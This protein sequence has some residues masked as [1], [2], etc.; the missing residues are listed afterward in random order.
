MK[1]TSGAITQP[2][3]SKILAKNNTIVLALLMFYET[4]KNPKKFFK[5]LSCVIYRI[6]SKYFYIYY[7]AS[8]S[9]KI[10]E[11]P[12]SNGGGFKHGDKSYDKT[13][14]IGIPD[15]LMN[16]MSCHGFLKKKIL[17]SY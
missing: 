2:R 8:E 3:I 7:L 5:V 4:R 11:L 12:V 13:L 17:L 14:G 15:L 6:I 1:T 9:K 10:S 16:L